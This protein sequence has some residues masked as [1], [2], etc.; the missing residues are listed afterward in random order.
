MTEPDIKPE[1]KYDRAQ[2]E[3]AYRALVQ[4]SHGLR[5]IEVT[6]VKRWIQKLTATDMQ[7]PEKRDGIVRLLKLLDAFYE[8]REV[9]RVTGVPRDPMS[10]EKVLLPL[11]LCSD[12]DMEHDNLQAH[13]SRL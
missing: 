5:L 13:P 8:C 10:T 7:D 12:N 2:F 11:G 9:M 3:S 4:L 6:E 1:V